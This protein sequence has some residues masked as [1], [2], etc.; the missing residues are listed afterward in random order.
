MLEQR[1]GVLLV[2]DGPRGLG[3]SSD[4][5]ALVLPHRPGHEDQEA[6]SSSTAGRTSG[7]LASHSSGTMGAA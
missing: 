3:L 5:P 1:V 7:P 6:V 4:D 2:L